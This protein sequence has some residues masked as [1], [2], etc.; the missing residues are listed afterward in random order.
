MKTTDG[1]Q[2]TDDTLEHLRK[3][4]IQL[5]KS[6]KRINDI[7]EALGVHRNTVGKWF[8]RYNE[9][10]A[11]VFKS[12]KRGRKL[13]T[14]RTLTPEQ[15]RE[16]QRVIQDKTPDQL[17]LQ[18]ALWNRNAIKELIHRRYSITMPIRT[19]GE[20]LKRWGFTPQRPLKKA[21]EQ[22]PAEIQ[23]WLTNT[24]PSIA[25]KAKQE[26]AEI[27]WGDETGLTN[28]CN[29]IRGYAPAG[30]TPIIHQ[31]AKRFSMSMISSVTNRGKVRFMCYEGAMNVDIFLNFLK[32]LIK[33][34]PQKVFLIV[35]NLRVHH[36]KVVQRWLDK[37]KDQIELFHLPAY[38]PERNPDEYL[39]RDLKLSLANKHPAR[40]K[41]QLKAHMISH[42]RKIQKLPQRVKSYFR[43]KEVQ[44]A[45]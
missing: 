23:R 2:L 7:A 16:L 38:S 12:K 31:N 17:K 20:Y 43:H 3:Q 36:A 42:M 11:R 27:Q 15:E 45:A 28:E 6:G 9:I 30:Q 26:G 13:G 34:N 33:D 39:N 4:A 14:Q 19:V 1:R 21:Y 24:Y 25:Q 18:F 35:D 37:H 44:Y 41:E 5:R 29:Y 22:S 10:G 32:R 8:K 40:N